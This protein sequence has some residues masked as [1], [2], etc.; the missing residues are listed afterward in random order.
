MKTIKLKE[1]KMRNGEVTIYVNSMFKKM[2]KRK[3]NIID[4]TN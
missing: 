2:L 3:N 1:M 4:N